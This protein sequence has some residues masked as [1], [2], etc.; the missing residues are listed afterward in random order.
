MIRRNSAWPMPRIEQ[1]LIGQRIPIRLACLT[2]RGNPLVC[3]LWYLWDDGALWCAT[4]KNAR[5]VNYLRDHPTCGFEIAPESLPYRG[6]RG[7]G[8]AMLVPERGPEVL[9]RL[10]DRYLEDR[11]SEFARWLIDRSSSETAVRIVPA[12]LTSWDFSARMGS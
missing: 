11:G 6:V 10:I 8:Q 7:Q 12:W 1:F 3:S 4:Q 9:G 5:L 2:P